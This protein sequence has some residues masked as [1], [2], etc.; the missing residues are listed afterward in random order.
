MS[1]HRQ[2]YID[3]HVHCR[4]NIVE[5]YKSTPKEVTNLARS[6]GIVAIGDMANTKLTEQLVR[7]LA[8]KYGFSQPELTRMLSEVEINKGNITSRELVELRLRYVEDQGCLEG[9]NVHIGATTDRHQLIEAMDIATNHPRVPGIKV[10]IGETTNSHSG[11]DATTV[12]ELM[13]WSV[14]EDYRGV[15]VFHC[16]KKLPIANPVL[17]NP[18]FPYTWNLA[19]PPEM[20]IDGV[21]DV[22]YYAKL[23]GF[24]GH[25]HIAHISVPE[26]VEMV[27]EAKTMG[28]KISCASN[29]T[30]PYSL[31]QGVANQGVCNIQ[32]KPAN[33]AKVHGSA[34]K[35]TT[36][37]WEDNCDRD[38]SRAAFE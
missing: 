30:P 17:W 38:G 13:R 11:F 16:E 4:G 25:I 29:T 28:M 9:Y 15:L 24:K 7:Q 19:R 6:Q 22:I 20:E 27:Y 21:W 26:A 23:H 36:S 18:Q 33:Q 3:M 14:Q 31:G 1:A 34:A 35:T 12:D 37:G 5:D 32:G 2:K 10:I 8:R